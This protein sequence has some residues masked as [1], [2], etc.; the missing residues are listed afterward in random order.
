MMFLTLTA[1]QMLVY[2]T[3][4]CPSTVIVLPESNTSIIYKC[5]SNPEL[6]PPVYPEMRAAPEPSPL[7]EL[8][9]ELESND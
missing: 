4:V 5:L 7:D 2:M 9:K 8:K 6:P 1:A 3:T